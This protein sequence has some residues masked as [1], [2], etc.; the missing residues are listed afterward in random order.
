MIRDIY[1][2]AYLLFIHYNFFWEFIMIPIILLLRI[3]VGVLCM[4]AAESGKFKDKTMCWKDIR[5]LTILRAGPENQTWSRR[6]TAPEVVHGR[7]LEDSCTETVDAWNELPFVPPSAL[8]MTK[9]QCPWEHGQVQA[10]YLLL[11]CFRMMS[12]RNEWKKPPG[13]CWASSR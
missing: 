8:T 1:S 6:E 9:A 10:M 11:C 7:G 5:E 4:L 13:T 2:L 12:G 3:S